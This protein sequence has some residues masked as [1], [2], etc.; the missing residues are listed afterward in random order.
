MSYKHHHNSYKKNH[1]FL[2]IF[3]VIVLVI[4]LVYAYRDNI[5][6]FANKTPS[7]KDIV[8]INAIEYYRDINPTLGWNLYTCSNI[9]YV[10]EANQISNPKQYAC[11]QLC[12]LVNKD[13]Y[14]NDCEKDDLICY[15]KV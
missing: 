15:C 14:S 2:W 5:K 3:V 4:T 13:Y 1:N 9:E 12:G 8:K 6:E 10:G 7:N 11:R